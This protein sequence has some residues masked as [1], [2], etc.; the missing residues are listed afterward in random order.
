[1]K[2]NAVQLI[3]TSC[4]F[5]LTLGALLC[6]TVIMADKMSS[7]LTAGVMQQRL[8]QLD[9]HNHTTLQ[10]IHNKTHHA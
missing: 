1:M 4:F 6:G 9:E 8:A 7:E 10:R 3:Y 2:T 5:S